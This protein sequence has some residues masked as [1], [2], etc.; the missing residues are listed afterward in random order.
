MH[1]RA[2]LSPDPPSP[3]LKTYVNLPGAIGFTV[4][5]STLINKFSREQVFTG[6]VG[7]FVSFF[8]LFALVIYPNQALLHP[9]A[10]VD[11]LAAMLPAGF[12]APLCAGAAPRR[13]TRTSTRR[14][15]ACPLTRAG[16]RV[17]AVRSSG[18]GRSRSSTP[19][20]RHA[21]APLRPLAA[22]TVG[23]AP[24]FAVGGDASAAS[25]CP[26]RRPH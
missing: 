15:L 26:R 5:Y 12:A 20:P 21:T 18:T 3:F 9:T 11:S 8:A 6:I 1:S 24:P 23:A 4:L 13:A 14:A 7:S 16:P 25:S 2:P 19:W 17:A 22:P 10:L